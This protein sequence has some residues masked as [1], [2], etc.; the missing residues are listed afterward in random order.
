MKATIV[1]E[2]NWNAIQKKCTNCKGT[3]LVDN[4]SCEWCGDGET[5]GSKGS[6]N[7]YRYVI[8]VG[9]SRSSKTIS[10][11]Q[12][13]DIYSRS[14]YSKRWTIWRNVKTDCK[15][16]VLVDMLKMLKREGLYNLNQV[17]NK[18]E[19]IF[20]YDTGSTVEI[21]GTDD[22]E[23]VHGLTQDNAH[24]NEP[25]K[26]S[27]STFDQIDQR[28]SEFIFLDYNPKKGHWAEDL[29]K[30][31]RAIVIHSTFK[32]NPFCPPEQRTK[33]LGYQPL[34]MSNAVLEKKLTLTEAENYDISE[35]KKELSDKEL[36]ELSRCKINHEKNSASSFN[37]KVYGLGLK[38]E[39]PNRIFTNWSKISKSEFDNLQTETYY[40]IDW[41]QV[42]P[43]GVVE[44]KYYDNSLYINELNY[45][46][47]N[48]IKGRLSI[49][50]LQKLHNEDEGIVSWLFNQINVNKESYL[51]CDNNRPNKIKTLRLMGYD[52]SL[53]A[54]KGKGSI[55]DGI[56]IILNTKVYYTENS[57]NLEH[58]YEEYQYK[59]DRMGVLV[60][61]P[62]DAD[63]H[64][65]DC[66]RY[67]ALFLK[68]QQIIN[69]I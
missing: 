13:S 45:A 22:E 20:T 16:T 10:L 40:G 26:I 53:I 64:L 23:T 12:I 63:N 46:S 24:L 19:S 7:Y 25:Y 14:N 4:V 3:G 37:W 62:L 67:V 55:M 11:V 44:I 32:D 51:I 9:S 34:E 21:H 28:T 54:P 42:D 6:G 15:K 2:K 30:D 5:I 31:K 57:L 48:E 39:K 1:F 27:R 47:E 35:N 56:D 8:N 52:Y 66:I 29:M 68:N 61:E 65:I 59:T 49:E 38:S 17:F 58:E 60:D 33:I 36:K 69:K 43:F 50:E 41:G 18:T